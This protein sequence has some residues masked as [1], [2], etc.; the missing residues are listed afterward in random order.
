MLALSTGRYL[1]NWSLSIFILSDYLSMLIRTHLGFFFL[2]SV[3]PFSDVWLPLLAATV[4]HV[5]GLGV[6]FWRLSICAL[7]ARTSSCNSA[8]CYCALS[9]PAL[10]SWISALANSMTLCWLVMTSFRLLM[11]CRTSWFVTLL[12]FS[13][14]VANSGLD[15]GS[16]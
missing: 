15:S 8:F 2:V 11:S 14:V 10:I 4:A 13:A 16:L 7:R 5:L 12:P 6:L 9:Y 1:V 3:A